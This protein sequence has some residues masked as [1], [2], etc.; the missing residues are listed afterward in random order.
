MKF[1]R[2]TGQSCYTQ[3]TW[4]CTESSDGPRSA[5]GEEGDDFVAALA[6]EFIGACDRE[7]A[8]ALFEQR[9][10]NSDEEVRDFAK[11][12]KTFAKR[13]YPTDPVQ[14]EVMLKR[15]LKKGLT[16][17]QCVSRLLDYELQHPDCR[18]DQLVDYLALHDPLYMNRVR[19]AGTGQTVNQIHAVNIEDGNNYQ[20]A[21]RQKRSND[22]AHTPEAWK[23]MQTRV[24]QLENQLKQVKANCEMLRQKAG[25]KGNGNSK[26]PWNRSDTKSER[27]K[28]KQNFTLKNQRVQEEYQAQYL[29]DTES[30]Q[31]SSWG[32]AQYDE[33]LSEEDT[34]YPYSHKNC[35]YAA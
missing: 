24:H 28:G 18:F 14:R 32:Q 27:S 3:A 5:E 20:N 22:G 26:K 6:H 4:S 9:T 2:K 34:E 10:Q 30:S 23:G 11:S 35:R 19:N 8:E 21:F 15:Q 1:R 33:S 13:A 29:E 25:G 12:L 31:N 17:L 7:E 16:D